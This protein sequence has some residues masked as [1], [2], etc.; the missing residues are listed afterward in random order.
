MAQQTQ[1]ELRQLDPGIRS[2]VHILRK[3]GIETLSSCEGRTNPGYHPKRDGPHHG[4]W[5]YII[6]AGTAADALIAL[7]VALR[8]GLPV[9]S[10]EQS[11]FVYPCLLYTSD[12][13]DEEDSV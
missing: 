13:A 4:D 10:I 5:P 6:L 3:N 1:I 11:W 9:R 12:A 8:E 2:A 7:G